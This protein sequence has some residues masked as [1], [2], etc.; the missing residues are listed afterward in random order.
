MPTVTNIAEDP[1]QHNRTS[2]AD[3]PIEDDRED[4]IIDDEL[5]TRLRHRRLEIDHEIE[6]FK[7]RKEIEF[8]RFKEGLVAEAK[9]QRESKKE[10][11]NKEATREEANK[12]EVPY[13]PPFEKELQVAGLFAPCY[14][15]LLEDR[16]SSVMEDSQD[17]EASQ[18]SRAPHGHSPP[19]SQGSAS[20]TSTS[21]VPLAS[22]LK[23]SSGSFFGTGNSSDGSRKSQKPK[24][25][26]KVT[27][28]FDDEST[29]PSRSSP[30]PTK[31]VWSFGPINDGNFKN[32]HS[33]YGPYDEEL[34]FGNGE[35]EH[36]E[37]VTGSGSST[38]GSPG[39]PGYAGYAGTAADPLAM[40]S[41]FD[42]Q[43]HYTRSHGDQLVTPLAFGSELQPDNH[44]PSTSPMTASG[45][46]GNWT[47]QLATTSETTNGMAH[48]SD[49]DDG[50]FDL[51]ETV[52]DLPEQSPPTRDYSPLM[53]AQL[54]AQANNLNL[55]PR[56][57]LS[58]SFS[59]S[60]PRGSIPASLSRPSALS[61]DPLTFGKT[62]L[63][64]PVS[65]FSSSFSFNPSGR[66]APT[67]SLNAHTASAVTS[68]AASS[69]GGI[70][71][72]LP[73]W[74]FHPPAAQ[75]DNS[76]FRRRSINKYI[77]SPPPEEEAEA[78]AKGTDDEPPA[79]SI[80]GSSLPMAITPRLSSLRSPPASMSPVNPS[81]RRVPEADR[82]LSPM[83]GLQAV[84]TS[85]A[86]ASPA[87]GI[88]GK[89]DTAS[90]LAEGGAEQANNSQVDS[91]IRTQRFPSATMSSYKT[92]YAEELA[93]QLMGEGVAEESVV[94]GV[95]G[96]TGL[97]PG[98]FSV[99]GRGSYMGGARLGSVAGGQRL[100][101]AGGS[102]MGSLRGS[103]A[104]GQRGYSLSARMAEEDEMEEE[105]RRRP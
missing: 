8:K 35:I 88:S 71:S 10:E 63:R 46:S 52:P 4:E 37:N 98:S 24:S 86:A 64:A 90:I 89:L 96:R 72:S 44:N 42:N 73:T 81:P 34:E 76:R 103:V 1:P 33:D 97:D 105:M 48:D 32:E 85:G 27:F 67:V 30:P 104:Q 65:P 58:A 20:P 75:Q 39:S 16:R 13:S 66:A 56:S 83:S 17:S 92:K 59:A 9:L 93:T 19:K 36:V 91:Y 100:S 53:E 2:F 99:R 29:V 55:N 7:K 47:S 6:E 5:A 38:A 69:A 77:P 101:V 94:G 3:A 50:L 82:T 41:S 25:P 70:P 79:T 22:S 14:L 45:N 102:Y 26:K 61:N 11:L 68:T 40:V 57:S 78:A 95:D 43:T 12:K 74:G 87:I 18:A 49:S 51:D 23:S 15:P 62:P 80:Y 84:L 60:I 21:P 28:Q 54:A 31:V